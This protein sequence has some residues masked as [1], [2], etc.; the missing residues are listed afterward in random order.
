MSWG[1]EMITAPVH[2][3]WLHRLGNLTLTGYNSKYS[4]RPFEEKKKIAGGFEESSV[5]L[6]KYVRE[7]EVWTEEQMKARGAT[8][9]KRALSVWP[10]LVVDQVLVD[11]AN[12]QEVRELAARRDVSKVN[13]TPA[14]RGIFQE[15]QKSIFE[16]AGDVIE[17]AEKRS[18]S[19]HGPSF[20]LEVLPRKRHLALLLDLDFNE[21]EDPSGIAEDATQW[22][23]F[24]HA[25]HEGGVTVN[26]REI[27]EI[28]L[29]L[30]LIRQAYTI[31]G[32]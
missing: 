16:M 13:M 27:D 20:F 28:P 14:A 6:N 1:V 10:P 18:V 19:Y 31:S 15:L 5:R 2:E 7:Q 25:Q 21:I 12:E 17:L 8:L 9:A 26:V 30:P 4:D 11:A 22:S 29:V 23:F 24:F 32:A 3:T